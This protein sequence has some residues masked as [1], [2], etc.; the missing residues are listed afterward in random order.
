[1]RLGLAKPVGIEHVLHEGDLVIAVCDTVHEEFGTD[2]PRLHWSIPDPVRLDTDA[3]FETA[4]AD[5]TLRV[6]RL[7]AAIALPDG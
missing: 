3:A 2:R 7:A 5:I 1:M 4:F 6:E